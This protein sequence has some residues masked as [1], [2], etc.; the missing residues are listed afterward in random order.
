MITI[1]GMAAALGAC[2]GN[3]PATDNAAENKEFRYLIDEFTDL[4]I[5]RYQIPGWD[6]LTL[7]QKEYVYHLSEAAKYGRDIIW[8]QNYKHNLSV[9]K[10][11]ETILEK[12]DGDRRCEDFKKFERRRGLFYREK[13]SIFLSLQISFLRKDY[14]HS[15]TIQ[16]KNQ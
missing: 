4:K 16:Q 13:R 14:L 12:Y 8:A 9:R 2:S 3:V 15:T 7:Q 6:E 10:A 5:M 11:L 1:T